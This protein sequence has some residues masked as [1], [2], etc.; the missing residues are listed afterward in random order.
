M[1]KLFYLSVIVLTLSLPGCL[2]TTPSTGTIGVNPDNV[3]VAAGTQQLFSP[4]LTGGFSNATVKWSIQGKGCSAS[5]CGTIDQSGNYT[6]PSA[7]PANPSIQIVAS[8]PTDSSKA[9]FANVTIAPPVGITVNPSTTQT[10]AAGQSQPF[11]ATITNTSNLTANWTVSGTGCTGAACGT[12]TASTVGAA[13]ATYTAPNLIPT[14]PTITIKATSAAD[15]TKS[16]SV[17]VNLILLVSVSPL[18]VNV[19]VLHTQPFTALVTGSANQAVTWSLSGAGCSGATC[20]TIDATGNYTA[21]IAVPNPATVTVTATSQVDNTTQGTATV[22]V[23]GASSG[24]LGQLLGRYAFLYRGYPTPSGTPRVEAGSL[25]F[26][27]NGLIL[28]G[29]QIDQ[30][31]G[32]AH[33]QLAVTGSYAFDVG[34]TN[35]GSI[36]LTG[37]FAGTL[38]FAIVPHSGAL[39]ATAYLTDFGG[40]VAGAG[41]LEGQDPAALAGGALSAGGYAISM[42][43][44]TNAGLSTTVASAVGR[45]DLSA[46]AVSGGEL[47]RTFADATF[48]DCTATQTINTSLSPAYSTFTGSYGA[49]NSNTGLTSITL[50]NVRIGN[51]TTG[52]TLASMTF[53]AYVVSAKQI[54]L[55][56]TD[57]TGFTFVG[58]AE[59]QSTNNFQNSSY[60]GGYSMLMQS[61]NGPGTGNVILTP[62]FTPAPAG[63]PAN[64]N[65][66][67]LED[68]EYTGNMDGFILL[69]LDIG[70]GVPGGGYYEMTQS[71][72]LALTALC[73][74]A[75]IPRLVMYF[76]SPQRAFVWNPNSNFNTTTLFP[77]DMVGEFDLQQGGPYGAQGQASINGTFAF[78]FEGVQGNFSGAHTATNAIAESGT[79]TFTTTGTVDLTAQGEGIQQTGTITFTIDQANGSGVSNKVT[80]SGTFTFNDDVDG[81][82]DGFDGESIGE[83][84]FTAP[85]AFPV[86]DQFLVVSGNKILFLGLSSN[87]NIGGVAQKQ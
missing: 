32:A 82:D 57:T 61:N 11:T 60:S 23:T 81:N 26:D 48:G 13:P 1:K 33:T 21:P 65:V 51:N 46:G 41:R 38:K 87:Y 39:A 78:G 71:N 75:F 74:G 10:L 52:T 83:I 28:S 66:P 4:I 69:G 35:R 36:T 30:N 42:R 56:E 5:S 6:A 17:N 68:G 8:I 73:P 62:I 84:V 67:N 85:P 59:L 77:S 70:E 16:A 40:T 27:G 24:A 79:V 44:G 64:G 53:A 3:T 37:G 7:P 31:S 55:L 80:V 2:T 22:T 34:S 54:F 9:G 12:I 49:V 20:G 25:L 76:V 18:T 43:G 29:S 86:P 58:S 15:N 19:A 63:I 45:F 72:G 50:Q 14:P 47:G